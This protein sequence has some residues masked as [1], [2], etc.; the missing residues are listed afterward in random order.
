MDMLPDPSFPKNKD[1]F[2]KLIVVILWQMAEPRPTSAKSEYVMTSMVF[3]FYNI[4]PM[5]DL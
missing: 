1:S 5:D 4:E 3:N 2:G